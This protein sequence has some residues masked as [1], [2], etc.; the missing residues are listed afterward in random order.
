MDLDILKTEIDKIKSI[1]KHLKALVGKFKKVVIIG[2]G[3]SNAIASHICVD[4][5]KF[6]KKQAISF[7]DAPRLTA[8]IND[9][10]RDEAYK[11]FISEF[12]NIH[13]QQDTLVI[14][15]SSSGNS[16]NIVNAAYYCQQYFIPFATLSGFDK[17][18]KLNGTSSNFNYWGDSKSYGVV[19]CAHE[20]LLHSI[21][22]N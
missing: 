17:T 12:V 14:L 6:L 3:G 19:E 15:I 5:T 13:G 7:S 22:D 4:Y 2:N 1:K 8:Y 21:I 20:I 11:Q 10:G 9:Y 16:M 18:N